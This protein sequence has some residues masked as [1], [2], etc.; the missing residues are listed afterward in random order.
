MNFTHGS[1]FSG[2]GGF[3]LAA[4]LMGW[5]NIFHCEKEPFC[6]KVLNYHFPNSIL[7]DDITKTDFSVYRG[8]IDI[9]TGGFPCQPFSVAGLQKGTEDDRHLW[10]QM[11]RAIRE[12]KPLWI[13][14][15]NVYGLVNWNDGLVFNQVQ[16]DLENEGYEV[17][18]FI[19]PACGIDAPHKRERVWFIAFYAGGE[20]NG[21]HNT[22]KSERHGVDMDGFVVDSEGRYESTNNTKPSSFDVTNTTGIRSHR[23]DRKRANPKQCRNGG[24]AFNFVNGN[25]SEGI[26]SN[27]N[28]IDRR[29]GT[30]KKQEG[31]EID[32]NSWWREFPTQ[33][34][35]CNGNDGISERLDSK[36]V[37]EVTKKSRVPDAFKNWREAS[38]QSGGNAIVPGMALQIFKAIEQYTA[39]I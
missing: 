5:Q 39:L 10:P 36:A 25:G 22:G 11:L 14:G 20:L 13:V 19:L 35:I 34:P 9:L 6:Q 29:Q 2:I 3:D 26:T 23:D 38:I 21:R 12:I 1:L 37:F 16:V 31:Q 18:A 30:H 7:H 27:S 15:E 24:S 4:E 32:N 33:S 28:N 8:A 17:Q